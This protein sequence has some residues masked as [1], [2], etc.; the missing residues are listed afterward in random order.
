MLIPEQGSIIWL[1]FNP[2]RGK[3]QQGIRPALVF[4]P[5]SYNKRVGLLI[6]CPIT[7]KSKGYQFEVRL[8]EKFATQGVVLIDQIR[9]F[10]WKKRFIRSEGEK[11]PLS[12]LHECSR[13]ISA[14]IDI[15]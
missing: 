6:A 1:D 12:F 9:A 10:D 8:P 3:E 14:L 11:V 5:A 13:I 4:T 15:R 2:T 7:N